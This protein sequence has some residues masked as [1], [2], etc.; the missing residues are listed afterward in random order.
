MREL[1]ESYVHIPRKLWSDN[2]SAS[3]AITLRYAGKRTLEELH[4]KIANEL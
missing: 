3:I 2:D 4:Q 1:Q